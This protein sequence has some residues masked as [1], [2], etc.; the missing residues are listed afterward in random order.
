MVWLNDNLVEK[1]PITHQATGNTE[2]FWLAYENYLNED[3]WFL[4]VAEWII[5]APDVKEVQ[6]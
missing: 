3:S 1:K 6:G 5:I 2:I 4:S